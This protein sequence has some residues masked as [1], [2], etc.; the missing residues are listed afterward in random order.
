MQ[1]V[2]GEL[3]HLRSLTRR[4]LI[5]QRLSL[6]LS[7]TFAAIIA[8]IAVDFALRLPGAVRL[9]LLAAGLVTLAYA[10]WSYLRLAVLFKPSLTQLALRIEQALPGAG[11]VGRLAS[12]VEFALTGI[13]PSSTPGR[14]A[15]RSQRDT[16]SRLAG[17]RLGSVVATRRTWRDVLMLGVLA[18]VAVA[19]AS[20]NP[21]IAATGLKRVLLP[22]GST[23]W[24]A[25]TGV[26]SYLSQVLSAP[27]PP[28]VFPRG[29]AL[30]LRAHVTRGPIDQHV[31]ARYRLRIN[32]A[33]EP[34]QRIV[35]T[36][37]GSDVQD[38]AVHERLVDTNAQSLQVYFASD[39][40]QTEVELIELVPPPAVVRATLSVTPPPYA[41]ARVAPLEAELGPGVDDRAVT[42]APLLN[43]S[44]ATLRLELNKPLTSPGDLA[45]RQSWLQSTFGLEPEEAPHFQ[46][47]AAGESVWTLRWHIDGPR[48]LTVNLVD[49]HGLGNTEP[50]TYR[51]TAIEDRLPAV[52]ITQP[53]S[54]EAVLP[55]ATVP[56]HAE[57]RDDVAI[58]SLGMEAVVNPP[59]EKEGAAGASE[60][61]W[62]HHQDA[63]P[64]SSGGAAT[65][66]AQAEFDLGPLKLS[67]G[68]V[69]H[70]TAIAKDG[71]ELD[72]QTHEAARSP[73]RRLRVI[74]ET[75]FAT[76]LRRQ[77]GAVRQN[78][79]RIEALQGELQDD[80]IEGGVQPGMDRAQAQLGE[81]VAAQRQAADDIERLMKQNRLDDEQLSSIVDQTRDLLDH[82]GRAAGKAVQEIGKREASKAQSSERGENAK[83]ESRSADRADG[84][85]QPQPGANG[86][87]TSEDTAQPAKSEPSNQ[88]GSEADSATTEVSAAPGSSGGERQ[89]A[90]DSPS[91]EAAPKDQPLVEAQQE[92]RDE[93]TDLIK[94]LDRDEDTWVARRQ[95]ENMLDEQQRLAQET[96]EIGQRTIGKTRADLNE[97][98]LSDLDRIAQ[99]QRELRDKTRQMTPELRKRADALQQSDPQA[100]QGMRDAADRAEQQQL[101]RDQEDAAAKIEQNQMRTASAK[102]QS[103]QSTMRQM[104]EDMQNTRRAQAQEL[105]RRLSSLIESIQRLVNVQENELIALAKARDEECFAG[106]DR[107]MIRLTQN[108]Q[109]VETEARTAGQETR[110]VARSLGRAADAQGAAVTALRAQPVAADA[111][112]TAENHSLDLLKEA[113]AAAQEAQKDTQEQEM[114]RRREELIA[115]YRTHLEKQVAVRSQTLPLTTV[116]ELDRRQLVDARLMA[117]A[118]DQVRSG[119]A[120]LRDITREIMD[121][122]VFVHVHRMIDDRSL[123]VSE[124]LEM[125]VVTIDVTD[126]QQFI[127]DSIGRLITALEEALAPPDEFAKDES[128]E[129]AQAGGSGQP[130]EQ[131]I[132][133]ITQLK[134]LRGVQELIYFQTRDVDGRGNLADAQ[135]RER[136]RDLG[137]QQRELS[138]LGQRMLDELKKDMPD[139]EVTPGGGPAPDG[140]PP[141]GPEPIEP[142]T[143][144]GEDQS[145]AEP[146]SSDEGVQP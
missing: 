118:Q 19:F 70:V 90:D 137:Q 9:V 14:F 76:Q 145:P 71:F 58:T 107:G 121:S 77:L 97:E 21:T 6:M 25:R 115:A 36:H 143:P 134:L 95:I 105:I 31:Y 86:S 64:G 13:D 45:Q 112:E 135:R 15:A 18:I 54:D 46:F 88:E 1:Q 56:V 28:G 94:L 10:A 37:Q 35:L 7:G 47:D 75:E 42:E 51:I 123:A 122:P 30:P 104:L 120:E 48:L 133:P 91:H 85:E 43:G 80:V 60:P 69:V 27:G 29:Q 126:R 119:L 40:D 3:K 59:K 79:I 130:Q 100:A 139:P 17:E 78:A 93:L 2:I 44:D 73:E 89:P 106:V 53:Q 87:R 111:A 108:T 20:S 4:L 144:G 65:A 109:A 128:N 52:T 50:I 96:A 136:L 101:D 5:L 140:P 138:D 23:K 125:G 66:T 39:D 38:G 63:A 34:W 11:I 49:E 26:E 103:S 62:A 99:R 61:A 131:L 127:A 32:D 24:P 81:R 146:K 16:E 102:Q 82:A 33:W 83:A 68:D 117:A 72:G 116:A 114:R 141:D 129:G 132:P 55:T 110:R 92:V 74:G 142:Q 8:L 22:L 57:G 84:P 67:A 41:A 98:E 12:S 113:L 124:S